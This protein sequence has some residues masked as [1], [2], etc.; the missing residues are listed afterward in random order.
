MHFV[1]F[2]NYLCKKSKVG[3]VVR[4]QF[5]TNWTGG[6]RRFLMRFCVLFWF[7]ELRTV[8]GRAVCHPDQMEFIPLATRKKRVDWETIRV[9]IAHHHP[10]GSTYFRRPS[11]FGQ[12]LYIYIYIS[13]QYIYPGVIGGLLRFTLS[14]KYR[15]VYYKSL[16]KYRAAQD[17]QPIRQMFTNSATTTAHTHTQAVTKYR[18]RSR[19][20]E[21][22]CAIFFFF[23]R[24]RS[25][26]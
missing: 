13:L 5:S 18:S 3:Q 19:M 21:T 20:R 12:L 2:L 6:F 10:A 26:I 24:L 11:P 25:E 17:I 4:S 23:F 15:C 8:D 1:F 9:Y 22:M 16:E 7:R 14:R